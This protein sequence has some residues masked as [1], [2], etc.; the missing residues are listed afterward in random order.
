MHE[1]RIT[2][3]IGKKQLTEENVIKLALG[4]ESGGVN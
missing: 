2:G 3:E 1:G 4:G